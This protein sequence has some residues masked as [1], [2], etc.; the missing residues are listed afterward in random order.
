[1]TGTQPTST[2]VT[3]EAAPKRKRKTTRTPSDTMDSQ[4]QEMIEIQL[5]QRKLLTAQEKIIELDKELNETRKQLATA[6]QTPHATSHAPPLS[7]LKQSYAEVLV[8]NPCPQIKEFLK[9]QP[10]SKPKI[11]CAQQG[12]AHRKLNPEI[13]V[14]LNNVLDDIQDPGERLIVDNCFDVDKILKA[15]Y[16][17]NRKALFMRVT[18]E[19]YEHIFFTLEGRL[20]LGY[21]YVSVEESNRL[22][23]CMNC[24]KLYHNAANC[25]NGK[26]TLEDPC[27]SCNSSDHNP[28]DK[29]CAEYQKALTR[30]FANTEYGPSGRFLG[31]V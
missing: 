3:P 23:R 27:S 8:A 1:M 10:V 9:R 20:L 12:R 5:L 29:R 7:N 6:L 18:P 25:N 13:V 31:R 24:H 22:L 19:L 15:T 30:K 21:L 2:C 16:S 26:R 17:K 11:G 28:F 4:K 14:F